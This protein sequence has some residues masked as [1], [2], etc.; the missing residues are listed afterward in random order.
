[1]NED[2]AL[3]QTVGDIREMI[4]NLDDNIIVKMHDGRM[5]YPPIFAMETRSDILAMFGQPILEIRK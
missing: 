1:M 4:K 5:L 3:I 2:I